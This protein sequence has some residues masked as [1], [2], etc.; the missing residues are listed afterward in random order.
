MGPEKKPVLCLMGPTATGKTA[1][2][3]ALH[4]RLPVEIISADSSLVYRGMDI[5]TA[6]PTATELAEAPHRLIDIC[7][8]ADAYSAARFCADVARE[9][10]DVF[11]AGRL[12]LLV[13]GTMFY[14]RAYEFGLSDLPSADPELRRQLEREGRECGWPVMHARLAQRDPECARRI[15]PH[16]SQRILRALEI[17]ELSGLAVSAVVAASP[18]VA[19]PYHFVKAALIPAER[20][21]LHRRVAERFQ[22]MLE[23]GL[24]WEVEALRERGDLDLRLPSLRMVGYRQAWQYLTGEIN[25]IQMIDRAVAA[26]RQLAKRQLTWL[27]RYPGIV[28]FDPD[29]PDAADA[30]RLFFE[31]AAAGR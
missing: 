29:L 10:A 22:G 2:A 30:V 26:T 19:A 24:L 17:V 23:R 13:G 9:I 12:P 15:E 6:K 18:P 3:V 1:L 28:A 5:G 27:R 8:P 21:V 11:A 16:D 14:F 4:R 25:Y 20:A 7:D 31:R